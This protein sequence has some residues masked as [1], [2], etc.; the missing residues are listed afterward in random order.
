MGIR[1]ACHHCKE[2]LHLKDFLAGKRGK[3]PSCQKSFRIPMHSADYS[4]PIE[5][6][7]DTSVG[8][9]TPIAG[10]TISEKERLRSNESPVALA[11]TKVNVSSLSTKPSSQSRPADTKQADAPKQTSKP[12]STSPNVASS[13]KRL[14]HA[15]EA[16]P[17]AQWFVRP[18]SGGQYGPADGDLLVQWCRENR[19]T[20]ES[21]IWRE[22]QSQW[23]TAGQLLPE[24]FAVHADASP[25]KSGPPPLPTSMSSGL[26]IES[27][28]PLGHGGSPEVSGS[29]IA[30]TNRPIQKKV[31]QSRKQW[32]IIS[33][34]ATVCLCLFA[35]LILV[36]LIQK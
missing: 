9:P 31:Q 8:T 14:P 34:L 2:P 24:L 25:S 5:D 28:S 11:N 33:I 36:L 15:I 1:F 13:P 21:L 17:N 19:V 12:S 22:G 32:V 29:T 3:C 10:R 7:T 4:L 20:I 26:A 23:V 27:G 35:G 18:P 30:L 6:G 16:A